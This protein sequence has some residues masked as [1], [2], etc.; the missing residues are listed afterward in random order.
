MTAPT[1]V[2]LEHW[3]NPR[4]P[5]AHPLHE[6]VSVAWQGRAVLTFG[7]EIDARQAIRRHGWTVARGDG[8]EVAG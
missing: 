3:T 5:A 2:T 6:R 7:S 4:L 1:L 8:L